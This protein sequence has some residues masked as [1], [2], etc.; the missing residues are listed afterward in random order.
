M[1]VVEIVIE[2]GTAIV[3][4]IAIVIGAVI[5]TRTETAI[6]I[7]TKIVTVTVIATDIV[8]AIAIETATGMTNTNTAMAIR[9]MTMVTATTTPRF[10]TR[11]T[12]AGI[13]MAW[14]PMIRATKM[15]CTQVRTTLAAVR[16]MTRSA[17][18]FTETPHMDTTYPLAKRTSINRPIATASCAA[19][20]RATA[21]G[22]S[23]FL[24]GRFV[25]VRKPVSIQKRG[26]AAS[27]SP[28]HCFGLSVVLSTIS[29][30]KSGPV[31]T[32]TCWIFD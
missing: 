23:I 14:A 15:A 16:H 28:R 26:N 9:F 25:V 32:K 7:V 27:E 30:G 18:A 17:H 2:I 20:K 21:I 1:I 31:H 13:R 10:M 12:M 5:E 8:T 6:A 19:T 4:K 22:K 3:T 24:A 29:C 11:G